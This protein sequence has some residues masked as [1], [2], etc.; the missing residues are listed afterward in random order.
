VKWVWM[1]W[2]LGWSSVTYGAQ[3]GEVIQDQAALHD[4]PHTSSP[5]VEFLEKGER[6]RLS[7]RLIQDVDGVYWYKAR[8]RDQIWGYLKADHVKGSGLDVQMGSVGI[9]DEKLRSPDQTSKGRWFATLR[10]MGSGVALSSPFRLKGGGEGEFSWNLPLGSGAYESRRLALGAFYSSLGD[11]SAWG[12]SVIYRMFT[13]SLNEP[14]FRL[15]GGS[16]SQG[17]VSSFAVGLSGG[18]RFPLSRRL[19]SMMA[20]YLEGGLL[21]STSSTG[22][23]SNSFITHLSAGLGFHF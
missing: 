6:V 17:G 10:L 4:L 12:G 23:S 16:L 7:D 18:G 19:S 15:R 3:W 5:Q 20:L 13:Q 14:E 22:P 9:Q 1:T 21:F 11:A 2:F 8:T